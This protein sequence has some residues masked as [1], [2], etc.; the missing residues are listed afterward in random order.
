[1]TLWNAD[2]QPLRV[3][4]VAPPKS[5]V[6]REIIA[7]SWSSTSDICALDSSGTLRSF[8]R[9]QAPPAW[10]GGEFSALSPRPLPA[11]GV[12]GA[13]WAVTA[14][15]SRDGSRVAA[16]DTNGYIGIYNLIGNRLQSFNNSEH[17]EMT[18]KGVRVSA[19]A[20]S[21]DGT[22]L[23]SANFAHVYFNSLPLEV[24]GVPT[25]AEAGHP[26]RSNA[27]LFRARDRIGA[28]AWSLDSQ[29]IVARGQS[30][31]FL[32]DTSVPFEATPLG[33]TRP[34]PVNAAP[35][36]ALSPRGDVLLDGGSDGS[37]RLIK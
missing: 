25:P 23:A 7:V 19:V 31:L 26:L 17:Q 35:R 33:P 18:G 21:P 8:K 4:Q 10:E 12:N 13:A 32:L 9:T 2:G 15:F 29:L 1:L 34:L 27:R 11:P 28:L 22:H 24:S 20:W 36:I 6:G 37:W 5:Q 3:L 30:Q 14:A 16:G